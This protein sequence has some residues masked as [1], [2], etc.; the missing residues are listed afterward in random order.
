MLSL[1]A[2]TLTTATV[3]YPPTF[4]SLNSYVT[5]LSS[6]VR[7]EINARLLPLAVRHYLSVGLLLSPPAVTASTG[8]VTTAI[9]CYCYRDLQFIRQ[10]PHRP[11][12]AGNDVGNQSSGNVRIFAVCVFSSCV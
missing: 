2:N 8:P 6:A 10:S 1:P 12:T 11:S 5:T 4:P 7:E 9:S 3:L